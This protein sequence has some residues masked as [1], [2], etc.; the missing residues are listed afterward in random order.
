MG[1]FNSKFHISIYWYQ[2]IGII[3]ILK[4]Y[5]HLPHTVEVTFHND[6]QCRA[7]AQWSNC[8]IRARGMLSPPVIFS[9]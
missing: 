9:V 7:N 8:K 4:Q 6:P 2:K 5:I 3:G 1:K